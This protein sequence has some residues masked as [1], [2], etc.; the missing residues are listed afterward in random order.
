MEI[1]WLFVVVF[2]S[3]GEECFFLTF[4]WNLS[5][6]IQIHILLLCPVFKTVKT[7]FDIFPS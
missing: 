6:L 7:F 2:I 3:D 4:N 5:D 1:L